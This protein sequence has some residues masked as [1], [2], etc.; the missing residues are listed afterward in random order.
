MTGRVARF[1]VFKPKKTVWVN[2]GDPWIRKS[3][4]I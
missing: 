4:P 2:F 3:L 1:F